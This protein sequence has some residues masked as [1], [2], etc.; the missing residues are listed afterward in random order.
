M[1]HSTFELKVS[2]RR[3]L[4][5]AKLSSN[6]TPQLAANN[7]S[8]PIREVSPK[9]VFLGALTENNHPNNSLNKHQLSLW[10]PLLPSK[11][12]GHIWAKLL[13]V[14]CLA[15]PSSTPLPST[16]RKR[17]SHL[18]WFLSLFLAVQNGLSAILLDEGLCCQCTYGRGILTY[19]SSE[20]ES[21]ASSFNL[22][23]VFCDV[24]F[25]FTHFETEGKYVSM[26][27]TSS[28]LIP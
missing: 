20:S 19:A 9:M 15:L 22:F 25:F 10:A 4:S 14:L 16:W 28:P 8:F 1:T 2:F 26:L 7:N 24:F 6:M 27:A 21:I 17:G 11:A 3:A 12:K 13:T 5:I 18:S 23:L